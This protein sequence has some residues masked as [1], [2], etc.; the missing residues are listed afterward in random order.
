MKFNDGQSKF[1]RVFNF[2]I[3]MLLAKFTKI[4]CIR[5]ISVL[6]YT[7]CLTFHLI[8]RSLSNL[9]TRSARTTMTLRWTGSLTA[10]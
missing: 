3:F 10:I 4:R 1:S 6:Q 5:K 8:C 2:V 9:L 7:L